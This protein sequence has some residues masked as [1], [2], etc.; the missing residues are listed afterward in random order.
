MEINGSF[1]KS[2]NSQVKTIE[3][4]NKSSISGI[5]VDF[6]DN[7]WI[8]N[9][10]LRIEDMDLKDVKKPIEVHMMVSNP[11]KYLDDFK[12]YK[13]DH[14]IFHIEVVNNPLE[15][16]L[17]IIR[18]GIRPGIAINPDTPVELLKPY[19]KYIDMILLMSVTPGKGGQDF[20][21]NTIERLRTLRKMYKGK[22]EVDGGI[23]PKTI[24]KVRL[25]DAVV[26]GSYICMSD[27][28]ES[29]IQELKKALETK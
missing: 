25:S 8:K 4:L 17:E 27:N 18:R 13:I 22:I 24:K 9:N 28:Y 6:M 2:K 3:S 10:S 14:Y 15:V 11:L 21:E 12:E 5:H 1:L 23:N 19:L 29:R 20:L 26:C 7:T 16:I